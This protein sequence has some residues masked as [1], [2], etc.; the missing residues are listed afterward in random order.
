VSSHTPNTENQA[1]KRPDSNI[2]A[3]AL[4]RDA[5]LVAAQTKLREL[6]TQVDALSQQRTE[7]A[8]RAESLDSK[9]N[10]LTRQVRDRGQ[11]LD[12]QQTEIARQQDLLE[13]DRD[14][15]E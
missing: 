12:Q 2:T 3:E 1:A 6:Q 15:R 9:V 10:E 5:E 4:R 7:V 11:A 13:H 8:Q 14:I